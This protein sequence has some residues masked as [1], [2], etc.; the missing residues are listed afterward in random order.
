MSVELN[1]LVKQILT[2]PKPVI[3]FD[4][5]SLLDIIRV[6]GRD[7]ISSDIVSSA[8]ELIASNDIWLLASDIVS[9]EWNKNVDAV[10][11]ETKNKIKNT[12]K[13]ALM[14]KESLDKSALVNKWSYSNYMTSYNL[15]SELKRTSLQLLN[16][17]TLIDQDKECVMRAT[18][19]VIHGQPP[20]TKGKS[21]FKDCLIFEHCMELGKKLKKSGF[22]N[23]IL[24][25]SSNSSDFGSPFDKTAPLYLDFQ[26]A[27]IMYIGDIKT[28][29]NFI[30]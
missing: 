20:S 7:N 28:A 2:S 9:V 10:E 18:Q 29:I 26:N 22:T 12:H 15:E 21:E 5:C 8:L 30:C 24:F 25:V 13:H 11:Q 17:L 3:I 19:R 1:E 23:K 6:A 27:N 16:K 14:F 4:T